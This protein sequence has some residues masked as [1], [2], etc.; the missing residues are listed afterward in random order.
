VTAIGTEEFDFFVP[1]LLPMTIK[2]AFALRA[3]HPKNFRHGAF[4]P[5]TGKTKFE[6]RISK[7]ETLRVLWIALHLRDTEIAEFGIF[8][9]EKTLF[10]VPFAPPR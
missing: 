2:L 4:P 6:I 5:V 10:S 1:E 7:S 8:P 9:K 3:G